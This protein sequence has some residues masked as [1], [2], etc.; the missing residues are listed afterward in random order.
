MN[1]DKNKKNKEAKK[2]RI[3]INHVNNIMGWNCESYAEC[4]Q[5]F[6][7]IGEEIPKGYN[8]SSLSNTIL[9]Y[10]RDR[11]SINLNNI[12][13]N[14]LYNDFKKFIIC[15]Q[16]YDNSQIG[17]F[18]KNESKKN[19]LI[20]FNNYLCYHLLEKNYIH[21]KY[22]IKKERLIRHWENLHFSQRF[23]RL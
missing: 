8:L 17:N 20:L 4:S 13:S 2:R 18:I 11:I 3:I 10:L 14:K 6:A 9:Y 7:F 1:Y 21:H 19:N 15:N 5:M 16:N 22:T 12:N 23:M